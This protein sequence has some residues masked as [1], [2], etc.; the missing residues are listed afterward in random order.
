M[1]LKSHQCGSDGQ[2]PDNRCQQMHDAVESE[3][4]PISFDEMM[5]EY[6]LQ[7][8]NPAGCSV[9]RFCPWCGGALPDS[10][11]GTYFTEMTD[12]DL[13]DLRRR[14]AS[15]KS[16]D[17]VAA[18]IGT[19]DAVGEGCGLESD[20]W[21]RWSRYQHVWD[22]LILTIGEHADGRLSW[23]INGKYIGPRRTD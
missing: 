3:W 14:M 21:I 19:P 9:L 16:L 8:V 15:L 2:S 12:E 20:P 6:Q 1:N 10:L 22:S 4:F 5:G 11:R 17:E 13:E 23:T 18:A 7:M